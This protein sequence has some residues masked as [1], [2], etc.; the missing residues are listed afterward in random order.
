[1]VHDRLVSAQVLELV[2]REA[3]RICAGKKGFGPSWS[4]ASINALLLRHA[5]AGDHVVRLK[6]GDPTVFGRLD[7]EI[8]ALDGAG[9]PWEIVPGI[10]AA[11]CAAADM[12]VSLT[13]RGRN[14]ELRFLTGR[15]ADGFA[16]HDWAAWPGRA[17]LPRS[18]WASGRRHSC[19]GVS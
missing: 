16:E 17:P 4:Q 19:A 7:E 8:E 13:R 12:G 11:A 14:A 1:M 15:D 3:E 6:S 18:T 10:T 2:R 9:I 5:R